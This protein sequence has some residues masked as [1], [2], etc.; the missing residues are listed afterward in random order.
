MDL[1]AQIQFKDQK[2]DAGPLSETGVFH[3]EFESTA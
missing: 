2:K 3:F 1:P